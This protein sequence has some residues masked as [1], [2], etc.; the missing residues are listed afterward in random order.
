MAL[1]SA[2]C[3]YCCSI[4][5]K[6]TVT[7]CKTGIAVPT[8]SRAMAT[9]IHYNINY[10]C[11]YMYMYAWFQNVIAYISGTCQECTS[12]NLAC[13]ILSFCGRD[14]H[15]HLAP[16]WRVIHALLF[17]QNQICTPLF[18]ILVIYSECNK[19]RL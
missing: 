5:F 3:D 1:I 14:P 7:N 8:V 10:V 2:E 18:E 13:R 16:T 6:I 15:A 12:F 9:T 4:C 19:K 17:V 11:V